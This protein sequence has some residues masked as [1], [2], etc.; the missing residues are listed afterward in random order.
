MSYMLS[1]YVYK[2]DKCRIRKH[3][4]LNPIGSYEVRALKPV[5]KYNFEV[6]IYTTEN[7]MQANYASIT[8]DRQRYFY[9]NKDGISVKQ[10]GLYTI[11]LT[12]DPLM[13][14]YT[15]IGSLFGLVDRSGGSVDATTGQFEGQYSSHIA[16]EN[17]VQETYREV[18]SYEITSASL[19]NDPVYILTTMTFKK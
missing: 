8:L 5:G 1:L 7:I 18:G 16:D 2:D 3:S 9:I 12:L 15:Q 14:Y 11:S 17:I 4:F 10:N 19:P 6:T 13:T